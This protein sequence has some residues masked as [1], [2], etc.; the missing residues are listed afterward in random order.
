M[1]YKQAPNLIGQRFNRLLVVKRNGSSKAKK[2]LWLCYCD[3]GGSASVIT[4]DL[5]SG[6]SQSC[7]CIGREKTRERS[8]KHGKSSEKIFF[9]WNEIVQRCTKENCK[10]FKNYGGRGIKLY[11]KWKDFQTFY[12]YVS[13]LPHYGEKG[14]SLDRINNDGNY[15]PNNVRWATQREQSNNTRN[16][17][18]IVHNNEKHTLAEWARIYKT[19][20]QAM[21]RKYKKGQDIFN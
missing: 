12:D 19:D 18:W 16:N 17:I 20:Y 2:A 4:H 6:H 15:A 10:S 9:V 8:L 14:Y 13:A 3:C 11:D 5:L 21:Y 1:P 7:G